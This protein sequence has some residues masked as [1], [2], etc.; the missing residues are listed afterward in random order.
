MAAASTRRILGGE[1]AGA[2]SSEAADHTPSGSSSVPSS[3]LGA[4]DVIFSY[5]SLWNDESISAWDNEQELRF[6][7]VEAAGGEVTVDSPRRR[8]GKKAEASP[9]PTPLA[10]PAEAGPSNWVEDSRLA[11]ARLVRYV[12]R[13]D[14]DTAGY[15][16]RLM[17]LHVEPDS[18]K[19]SAIGINFKA[20][21]EQLF[22]QLFFPLNLPLV[23]CLYPAAVPRNLTFALFGPGV[24]IAAKVVCVLFGLGGLAAWTLAAIYVAIPSWV[25]SLY[26][27]EVWI[28]LGAFAL[29]KFVIATKY[30]TMPCNAYEVFMRQDIPARVRDSE[31]LIR[32]WLRPSSVVLARE[33]LESSS[34]IGVDLQSTKFHFRPSAKEAVAR[35]FHSVDRLI[36]AR[37]RVEFDADTEI[38]ILHVLYS[39]LAR[40]IVRRKPA[41]VNALAFLLALAQASLFLG[42]R[43]L[44]GVPAFGVGGVDT[45]MIIASCILNIFWLVPLFT[46]LLI[47]NTDFHMRCKTL[48][49]LSSV[50]SRKRNR[51]DGR[52]FEPLIDLR[53]CPGNV[54]AFV[55]ARRMLIN[56]GLRYQIR[57]QIFTSAV[58][59]V[60]LAFGAAALIMTVTRTAGTDFGVFEVYTA[61]ILLVTS[62]ILAIMVTSGATANRR[63]NEHVA[64][65]TARQL[66]VR[67]HLVAFRSLKGSM[68]RTSRGV[69]VRKP[70]AGADRRA[71]GGS[72][73][74]SLRLSEGGP[75]DS[76]SLFTP[77]SHAVGLRGGIRRHTTRASS[78]ASA[79]VAPSRPNAPI[80]SSGEMHLNATE[81]M[82]LATDSPTPIEC[83]ARPSLGGD[84][85]VA[86][87]GPQAESPRAAECAAEQSLMVMCEIERH[88]AHFD[89]VDCLLD[90]AKEAIKADADLHPIRLLGLPATLTLLRSGGV[91]LLTC[92]SLAARLLLT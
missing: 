55:L 73:S 60:A 50:I 53:V 85:H 21:I 32:G 36:P 74:K 77:R 48:G 42:Y 61:F 63:A 33:L 62:V 47:T 30:A 3:D 56:V 38:P 51:A 26:P 25:P 7:D 15:V 45:G 57:L 67:Q 12:A 19:G 29:Q 24:G 37:M 14:P 82:Q 28:M 79:T 6:A 41:K 75:S 80:E 8:R 23:W 88:I 78:S 68:A 40:D 54:S 34:R 81:L 44:Q 11:T 39:I 71:R 22:L 87:G 49:L 84:G 2:V 35:L 91:L 59:L 13:D 58:A 83:D 66:E 65:L 27:T 43:H 20:L 76:K 64:L 16:S 90:P 92:L 18:L 17:S 10:S 86:T 69:V 5:D 52:F 89:A 31:Q 1:S 9:P 72:P 46:F 4:N 70:G